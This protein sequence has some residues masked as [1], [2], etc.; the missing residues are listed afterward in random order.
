VGGTKQHPKMSCAL[1]Q[2]TADDCD[3]DK[4]QSCKK[5]F[6]DEDL[7][8]GHCDECHHCEDCGA[9]DCKEWVY[10]AD[11]D[12]SVWVCTY[13][14]EDEADDTDCEWCETTHKTEDKCPTKAD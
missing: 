10:D 8:D 6:L 4:C 7:D 14:Q 5:L 2:L 11:A 12:E 3:C 13:C 9:Q 1:C